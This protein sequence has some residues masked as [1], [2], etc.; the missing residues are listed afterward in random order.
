M[1]IGAAL[2]VQDRP[3]Q[4]KCYR[5]ADDDRKGHEQRAVGPQ[6]GRV[7]D[8]IGDLR[9]GEKEDHEG[10]DRNGADDVGSKDERGVHRPLSTP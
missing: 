2:P 8:E 4:S 6:V 10:H 9:H 5:Y 3:E 7:S 1:V